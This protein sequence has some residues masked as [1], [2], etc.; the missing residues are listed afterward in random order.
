ML[1]PDTVPQRMLSPER[2]HT[3]ESTAMVVVPWMVASP[4]PELLPQ[5]N[6]LLSH[7]PHRMFRPAALRLPQTI[8]VPLRRLLPHTMLSP[9]VTFSGLL[10]SR[11]PA[12]RPATRLRPQ[13]PALPQTMFVCRV[14]GPVAL[15]HRML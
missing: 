11:T 2:L 1:S 3:V 13:T 4:V 15:P 10:A 5:M 9:Q 12:T 14:I 8:F 6:R 7:V